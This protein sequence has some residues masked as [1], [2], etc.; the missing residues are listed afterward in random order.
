MIGQKINNRYRID[1]ELGKGGMGIVFRGYD[2]LLNRIVAVKVLN[3]GTLGSKGSSR[4]LREAQNA[5]QLN[6]PNIVTI[7]DAGQDG[8]IPFIVMEYVE[9]DSLYNL[10]HET[11]N[12]NDNRT[13]TQISINETVEISQQ[14]CSALDHAHQHDII[15]RDLKP[16]NVLLSSEGSAKLMDFGLARSVASRMTVEGTIIGTVFYLAPE[17]ALGQEYDGRADLYALGVMLYELLTNRFPFSGDDP[18]AVI[19]QHINSP[20]VP[21]R[22]HNEDI[23]TPLNSLIL[24]LLSKDPADRPDS[25]AQVRTALRASVDS[26]LSID[27]TLD[28]VPAEG[29]TFTVLDR[30][31]RGRLYGRENELA[32]TRQIWNKAAS[33]EGQLLLFSGEPG[34]GKT[35]LVREIATQIK[36]S[37]GKIYIGECYAEGGAPYEPFTQIL[38]KHFEEESTEKHHLPDYVIADLI[39]IAPTLLHVFPNVTENPKLNPQEEQQRL[40]ENLVTFFSILS[41]AHP[42]LLV[43]E[44]VHW[45]DSGTLSTLRHLARRIRNIPLMILATYREIELDQSLPFQNVLLD[46]NRERITTRM[47]LTRLNRTQTRSFLEGLFNEE[48]SDEF[49]DGIYQETEGNPFFIE[50]L[51]KSLVQSGKLYYADGEWH[52]P[53]MEDLEIPQSIRVVIQ[54][55]VANLHQDIQDALTISAVIGRE[56]DFD[57]LTAASQVDEDILIS[58]LE[59]AE[60][61][62]LIQ[63]INPQYGGTFS[64]M[65]ALIPQTLTESLSGLRKRRYHRQV[66]EAILE[67]RPDDYAALSHHYLQGSDLTNGL[68]FTIRAAQK[69]RDVFSIEETTRYFEKAAEVAESIGDNSQLFTIYVEIGDLQSASNILRSVDAYTQALE[70]ADRDEIRA[71]L[72]ASIGNA[73]AHGGD[74]RGL[75]FLEEA[76]DELDPET[77]RNAL[78]VAYSSIGRYHHYR[79]QHKKALSYLERALEIAEQSGE[80]SVLTNIYAHLSGLYQHLADYEE[81]LAW[82]DKVI[83][84]G[85]QHNYPLAVALGYEFFSEDYFSMGE[86]QKA[87][88]FAFK[89]RELGLKFGMLSRTAWAEFCLLHVYYGLGRLSD[90]ITAGKSALDLALTT[91]DLRLAIVTEAQLAIVYA[92]LGDFENAEFFAQNSVKRIKGMDQ[93]FLFCSSLG[94]NVYLKLLRGDIQGALVDVEECDCAISET[95]S[96]Q[97]PLF[98]SSAMAE[99]H[100]MAG[101][102]EEAQRIID[103]QL[104]VARNAPSKF[105]TS[106][107]LMVEAQILAANKEW[108]QA[109]N[110]FDQAA[111]IQTELNARLALGRT[112]YFRGL[113]QMG[114]GEQDKAIDVLQSALKLF[115]ECGA[116]FWV[117]YTQTQLQL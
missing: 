21:P 34:I 42:L 3:K 5:A 41:A 115:E 110:A 79:G 54:S 98:S 16:E 83:L 6:H 32:E 111:D 103:K 89:D 74:E 52:R 106:Q 14:V 95:D 107:Y 104:I 77:Q 117:E 91:G 9:G 61:A 108:E 112:L 60:Q 63:E 24:K 36:V 53:S 113:M 87:E 62:Q 25:A 92:D 7:F 39:T 96:K 4:L 90:C 59:A 64:F 65:H 33:G 102:Q 23:P 76:I 68:T 116:H 75:P 101:N 80:V 31:V 13:S 66:A 22:A 2:E 28:S 45:A 78:A 18:L 40:Y 99:V 84:L 27:S 57:T 81:S 70:L 67:N 94:A 58:A 15:H 17:L 26:S 12:R 55:R 48:V 51:C 47:K 30:I 71:T 69:S 38:R 35:R 20:V 72:K 46:L 93:I 8:E 1:R 56:F 114:R 105:F 43:L 88:K 82:A 73:Y 37:G 109:E 50:E 11:A 19:S 85:E 10:A 29:D 44:D 97:V 86:Y 49:L 100:I